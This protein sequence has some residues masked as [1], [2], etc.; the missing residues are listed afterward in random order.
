MGVSGK[1]EKEKIKRAASADFPRRSAQSQSS[2]SCCCCCCC[3][4]LLLHSDRTQELG[5]QSLPSLRRLPF[6]FDFCFAVSLWPIWCP[7]NSKYED[8]EH[9]T[10]EHNPE[11]LLALTKKGLASFDVLRVALSGCRNNPSVARCQFAARG[12]LVLWRNYCANSGEAS[13]KMLFRME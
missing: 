12:G 4:C 13:Q 7:N 1:K 3:C 6:Y 2:P 8:P 11:T 10:Q 9:R 5:R